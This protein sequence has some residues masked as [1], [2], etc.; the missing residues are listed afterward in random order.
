MHAAH[1]RGIVHRDLKPANVLLTA[2][3]TPKITDFGLAKQLDDDAGQTPD[4]RHPGHAQLHGPRAGRGQ[5]TEVGPAADVYAL[6]A[7]LYEMLTGRPPFRAATV[8]D[9]LQQVLTQEPVPPRQLQPKVPRDLETICLK[10]LQKDPR[11]ALRQRPRPWPTTCAASCDGEPIQ[12]RPVGWLERALEVARAAAGAG[13]A[14]R[15]QRAGVGA[16]GGRP[17]RR[18][19]SHAAAGAAVSRGPALQQARAEVRALLAQGRLPLDQDPLPAERVA[20]DNARELVRRA[21]ARSGEEADLADLRPEA[22]QP[23]GPHRRALAALDR[24]FTPSPANATT[25]VFTP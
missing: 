20:W 17:V 22:E 11:R 19:V 14:A 12:A 21:R 24:L 18:P 13:G 7:I 25:R 16:A 2:D 23:G 4:R 15:G 10:C 6:G 8:L 9:T 1:Q 3:G 5:G